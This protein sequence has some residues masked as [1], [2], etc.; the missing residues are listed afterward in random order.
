MH[1]YALTKKILLP[2]LAC[3]NPWLPAIG[4]DTSIETNGP[5]ARRSYHAVTETVI[6]DFDGATY[7]AWT[8]TGAAFGTGPAPGTLP[9]Q[10]PVSGYQ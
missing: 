9:D 8:A 3:L 5:D 2:L 6:A 1:P 4:A 10:N 7:G